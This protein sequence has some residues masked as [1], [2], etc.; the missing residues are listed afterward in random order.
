MKTENRIFGYDIIRAMA[1]LLVMIGHVLAYLYTGKYSFFLSFLSGFLG[2][3]LFF[4]L[5]GVLI[6][7]LLI[8]VFNSENF[9]NKM[10]NFLVR[11]WLRTLPLYFVMLLVYWFANYYLYSDNNQDVALWKYVFFIQNFFKVQPTFFG[12]SW[13]LSVEEWFY[14]LF[15]LVLLLIKKINTAISTK[16][17]FGIGIF[18]FLIYFLCMRFLAFPNSNF[19]FFEGV[20]KVAFFRL[21]SIAFGILMAFGFE[22]FKEII[23]SK[24][25]QLL[26]L[27]IL[28]LIFN[29]YFIF[30]NNYSNLYYFNTVY[31]SVLGLGIAL[32]FPFF[33]EIKSENS[34]LIKPIT[35]ISK[36]SYSLY[37][38]HWLVYKFL[39]LI[40][41]NTISGNLKFV[42]FFILSF[43]AAIFTYELIEK[44][45]M[46][47]RK[48]IS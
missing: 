22:Y 7:K 34:F 12:I 27:G 15:P 11:R 40:Y 38:V 31:Y 33:K 45:M 5:S 35:F 13:S 43:L 37:L 3:E 46:K 8:D 9:H 14:V 10:K 32:V 17:L 24:K 47:F 41:F 25:Y 1:I 18:I 42:L 16:K 48:K 29:Q 20:R 6:G 28:I 4:V 23:S 44:P 2:V 19:T 21:D 30:K 26:A 36:I 39:D